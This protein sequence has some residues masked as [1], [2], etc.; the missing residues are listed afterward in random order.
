V[1]VRSSP[2]AEV[3]FLASLAR[4]GGRVLELAIGTGRVA[5]PLA[6]RGI[7]AEGV[8]ASDKMAAKLRAK[9]GGDRR[10]FGADSADH[11]SVYR[12]SGGCP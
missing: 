8:E 12:L 6:A 11:V 3:D 10:P 4:S 7:A 5:L 9:P 2:V 1:A